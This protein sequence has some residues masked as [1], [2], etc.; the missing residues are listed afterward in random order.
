LGIDFKETAQVT[1]LVEAESGK[2]SNGG[3]NPPWPLM[4]NGQGRFNAVSSCS[5]MRLKIHLESHR[6]DIGVSILKTVFDTTAVFHIGVDIVEQETV[7]RV[8]IPV[9]P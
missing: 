9:D 2:F 6:E 3:Q 5:F 7:V 1:A 8:Q 4:N